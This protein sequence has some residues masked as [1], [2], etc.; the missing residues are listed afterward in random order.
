MRLWTI[1]HLQAYN[2]LL[3]NG[4]LRADENYCDNDSRF[5]YDWMA[6]KMKYNGLVSPTGVNYPIWA[7]C[8]FEGKYKRRDMRERGYAK[9][10]EKIVQ[11]T[12]EVD[13]KDISL[14]DFDLFHYVLNY[15]Y[16]PVDVSDQ[17]NFEMEYTDLGFGWNDLQNFNIQTQIMKDIRKKIEKSWDHI[18]DLERE[19][20]NLI[21]GSNCNKSIQVTFWELKLE[22]VIKA[23]VFIAR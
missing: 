14:T 3:E 16:L 10:G 11:L 18:F 21:Y 15:W 20:E 2:K 19:D 6:E 9:R 23:E 4:V 22:Q 13:D 7:W 17:E 5:A 12:I 1:Q 8:K